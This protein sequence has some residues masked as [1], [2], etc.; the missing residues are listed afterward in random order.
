MYVFL[1]CVSVVRFLWL[2]RSHRVILSLSFN[3]VSRGFDWIVVSLCVIS[4]EF[5]NVWICFEHVECSMWGKRWSQGRA[6]VVI[7]F[8]YE[9]VYGV[10]MSREIANTTIYRKQRRVCFYLACMWVACAWDKQPWNL[11]RVKCFV[12][13]GYRHHLHLSAVSSHLRP[14]TNN[15]IV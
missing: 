11:Y 7:V 13:V 5:P 6:L 2:E 15:A 12:Y 3:R 14:I 8:I 1:F 10:N 4:T 9:T